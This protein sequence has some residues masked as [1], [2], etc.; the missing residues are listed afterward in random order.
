V[1]SAVTMTRVV[2]ALAMAAATS[3]LWTSSAAAKGLPLGRDIRVTCNTRDRAELVERQSPLLGPGDRVRRTL[4][5]IGCASLPNHAGTVQLT[6]APR[7]PFRGC[8][9]DS[10]T[11]AR[12]EGGILCTHFREAF[13]AQRKAV[14]LW[15]TRLTA[16]GSSVALGAATSDIRHAYLWYW[17]GNGLPGITPLTTIPV[18]RKLAETLGAPGRFSFLAGAVPPETD[19]CPGTL[20]AGNGADRHFGPYNFLDTSLITRTEGDGGLTETPRSSKCTRRLGVS[21]PLAT[22]T[23]AVTSAIA[24]LF[25]WPAS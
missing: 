21:D 16:G 2:A 6:A 12:P 4:K 20:V 25:R 7:A 17:L 1:L 8:V 15:I 23:R 10:Y 24:A 14:G 9:L 18:G 5:V 22:A 3:T 13:T 11:V 19:L